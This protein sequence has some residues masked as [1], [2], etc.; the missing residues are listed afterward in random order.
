MHETF[1]VSVVFHEWKD[2]SSL[3]D[4]EN[5]LIFFNIE[6]EKKNKKWNIITFLQKMIKNLVI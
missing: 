1:V 6:F 3:V 4:F 5:C 2:R